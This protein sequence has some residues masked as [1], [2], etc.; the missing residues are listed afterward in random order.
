MCVDTDGVVLPTDL[1][2]NCNKQVI[3]LLEKLILTGLLI[4]INQG[5]TFQAF[6]G[7]VV[8]FSFFAVQC[9]TLPYVSTTD[10][11]VKA[12][13]EAQLFITLFISVVLRT[14]AS[15]D[16]DAITADQYGGILVVVFFAAPTAFL[17]S[18]IFARCCGKARQ[19]KIAA[20][21]PTDD[22]IV[23]DTTPLGD[24]PRREGTSEVQGQNSRPA[25]SRDKG[26][27][28]DPQFQPPGSADMGA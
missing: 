3:V 17:V 21:L 20:Y 8:A 15:E 1:D 24:Q 19:N 7:G 22:K 13:A 28:E 27:A 14:D 11:I 16:R 25:E 9:S 6:C 23:G 2:C 18:F 10:N 26:G 5:S 12:V 4:F